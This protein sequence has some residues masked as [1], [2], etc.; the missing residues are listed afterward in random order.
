MIFS[1]IK[2]AWC[3]QNKIKKVGK[4]CN[5]LKNLINCY[6]YCITYFLDLFIFSVHTKLFLICNVETTCKK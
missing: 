3:Y 1:I 4:H 6:I 2:G 5:K